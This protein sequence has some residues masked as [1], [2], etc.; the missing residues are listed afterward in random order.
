M[1][2]LNY[3]KIILNIQV[4][5]LTIISLIMFFVLTNATNNDIKNH[6]MAE[7]EV[8]M[9]ELA[10]YIITTLAVVV[11]MMQLRKLKYDRKIGKSGN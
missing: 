2:Y 10:L 8:N 4:I 6:R 7:F 3:S 1:L 11:A 9:V 5:V